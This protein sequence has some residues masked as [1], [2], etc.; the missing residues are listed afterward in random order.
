MRAIYE[1]MLLLLHFSAA[2]LHRASAT[3]GDDHLRTAGPAEIHFPELICHAYFL[4]FDFLLSNELRCLLGEKRSH[5][6]G[7]IFG[8]LEQGVEVF[9]QTDPLIER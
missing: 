6:L 3:F 4:L 9:F 2:A 1:D 7:P 8:G 5:S